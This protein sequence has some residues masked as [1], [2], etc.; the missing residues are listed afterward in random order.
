M[1]P[2]TKAEVRRMVATA[3]LKKY[4]NYSAIQ[5]SR[6]LKRLQTLE[7]KQITP[8]NIIRI[9]V[10][11][12][13]ISKVSDKE[14]SATE[15][16]QA[17]KK[18]VPAKKKVT[19]AEFEKARKDLKDKKVSKPEKKK[20]QEKGKK[21]NLTSKM[22]NELPDRI[23]RRLL[24]R[25][26]TSDKWTGSAEDRD[27]LYAPQKASA[28]RMKEFLTDGILKRYINPITRD[29]LNPD[30]PRDGDMLSLGA[31][32][33]KEYQSVLKINPPF[34]LIEDLPTFYI[35]DTIYGKEE[36]I[37]D[38]DIRTLKKIKV[39]WSAPMKKVNAEVGFQERMGL[40]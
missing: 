14:I 13:L 4:K 40:M 36:E 37:G 20:E 17:L 21:I 34:Y 25:V 5:L 2:K 19:K 26:M 15:A 39:G 6:E 16:R 23:L 10:I 3:A 38:I 29:D 1:P 31:K 33:N 8:A 32:A 18:K 11:K 35:I 27:I 28:K 7:K 12:K 22:V 30:I 9:D 24:V